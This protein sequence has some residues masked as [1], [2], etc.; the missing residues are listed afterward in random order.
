LQ[1][2]GCQERI[3]AALSTDQIIP[4]NDYI[5][6]VMKLQ[7]R[8]EQRKREDFAELTKQI[9]ELMNAPEPPDGLSEE[10]WHYLHRLAIRP[11]PVAGQSRFRFNFADALVWDLI[12]ACKPTGW[13]TPLRQWRVETEIERVDNNAP[14]TRGGYGRSK[15][16][17]AV[18][19]VWAFSQFYAKACD[20][21]PIFSPEIMRLSP[22]LTRSGF[23]AQG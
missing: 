8:A 9:Q 15:T 18:E 7:E 3:A 20:L 2:Q 11:R 22:V 6:I 14:R 23:L 17:R 12:Q 21:P 1:L 16:M 4:E 13:K 5:A 10:G 19:N